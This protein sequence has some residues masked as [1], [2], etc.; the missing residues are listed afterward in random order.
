MTEASCLHCFICDCRTIGIADDYAVLID[1][2]DPQ[3]REKILRYVRINDRYL[4]LIR[5]V[6]VSYVLRN[7][8]GDKGF[9][10]SYNEYGKPFVK[11][12]EP[13]FDFSVS[14]AG[15]LVTVAFG[16]SKVGVDVEKIGSAGDIDELLHFLSER[17]LRS[18]DSS[19]DR[20]KEFYRIWT[21]REALGKK[22]GMG[23]LLYEGMPERSIFEDGSRFFEYGYQD[24]QITICTDTAVPDCNFETADMGKWREMCYFWQKNVSIYR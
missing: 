1:R 12:F 10:I 17:E 8:L 4:H 22:E 13:F 15:D 20:E 3:T 11:G 19:E 24:Y 21:R 18:I 5:D 7:S 14:H 16:P 23:L 2:A 6:M 9:D